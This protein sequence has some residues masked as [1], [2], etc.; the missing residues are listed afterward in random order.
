MSQ[1]RGMAGGAVARRSVV[2]ER[3]IPLA[4]L[5]AA[6]LIFGAAAGL[7]APRADAYAALGTTVRVEVSWNGGNCWTRGG[8]APA[9]HDARVLAPFV[10]RGC[11]DSATDTRVIQAGQWFGA[12]PD[13]GD[14]YSVS[15]TVTNIVTGRIVL[16]DY[17]RNGDGHNATC[18][19]R[20]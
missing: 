15:C 8:T 1:S 2:R 9:E 18:L 20:A 10:V 11:H 12:D 13:I 14:A 5:L 7:S 19:G 16:I 3:V 4:W 17:A 6:M